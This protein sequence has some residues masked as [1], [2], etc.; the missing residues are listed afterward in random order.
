MKQLDFF[1]LLVGIQAVFAFFLPCKLL[2]PKTVRILLV[3]DL[4]YE[5]EK[6]PNQGD[7]QQGVWEKKTRI[8]LDGVSAF[9]ASKHPSTFGLMQ[10]G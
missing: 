4:S 5:I 2:V 10:G 7:A 3:S 6:A 8:A 9:Y 1:E